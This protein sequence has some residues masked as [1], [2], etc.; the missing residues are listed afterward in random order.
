MSTEKMFV[1]CR[2]CK[3]TGVSIFYVKDD[4]RKRSHKMDM[5][6]RLCNGTGKIRPSLERL[7]EIVEELYAS[8]GIKAAS[9]ETGTKEK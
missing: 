8:H 3:G 7:W 1:E 9:Q 2:G 6:C 4:V 5:A